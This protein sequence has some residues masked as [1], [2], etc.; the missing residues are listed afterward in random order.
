[1][2]NLSPKWDGSMRLKGLRR[3]AVAITVLNIAGHTVL[4]FEQSDS[5]LLVA[6]LAAYATELLLEC[7]ESLVLKRRPHF[8]GSRTTLLNFLLPAHITGCACAMLLYANDRLGVVVFAAAAGIASKAIFRMRTNG[9]WSHIFNPSNFG[10]TLTLL[11]FT[12]VGIAMPYQFTEKLSGIWNIILPVIFCITGFTLNVKFTKRLPLIVTWL[13]AFALQ[14][15]IR[16]IYWHTPIVASLLPMSGV[17]FLLYT[18]YMITDPATSPR[19]VLGQ[20][21]FGASVACTYAILMSYHVVY[22]LFFSLT[23]VC[24]L[25]GITLVLVKG[26]IAIKALDRFRV[27]QD[28][29]VPTHV[30]E[31]S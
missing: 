17:A 10:I 3:F 27:L 7:V 21:T 30:A 24:A 29:R 1:M 20:V 15:I 23:I 12:W 4:G 6:V 13:T 8:F 9:R 5:Q 28:R 19:S 25:R 2:E 11:L 16:G 22:G 14:A 26:Q 18:F 31:L